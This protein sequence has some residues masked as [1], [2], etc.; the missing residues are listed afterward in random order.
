MVGSAVATIVMSMDA[1][2]KATP[3]TT[4]M[5]LGRT[6][7]PVTGAPAGA[8]TLPTVAPRG[9]TAS[10]G[11]SADM[12]DS[13]ATGMASDTEKP[14][15]LANALRLLI[16]RLARQQRRAA[17]LEPHDLTASRLAALASLARLGPRTVGELAAV[18]GVQSPT[19]TRIVA[20][21]EERGLVDKTEDPSDRRVTRLEATSDGIRLLEDLR[22]RESA[23]LARRLAQM[24]VGERRQLA[25]VVPILEK[26]LPE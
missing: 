4:K 26:L 13:I 24:D 21:L 8:G 22:S 14:E 10:D 2:N 18:E 12:I 1:M 16:A 5:A 3:V 20:K 11:L 19:M 17:A 23:Y 9:P 7:G 25:Q 15:E 6:T